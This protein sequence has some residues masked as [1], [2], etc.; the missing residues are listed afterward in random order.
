MTRLIPVYNWLLTT[1]VVRGDQCL[2]SRCCAD[3]WWLVALDN[4]L[5]LGIMIVSWSNRFWESIFLVRGIFK[6]LYWLTGNRSP[7]L[8]DLLLLIS[9]SRLF[10][11]RLAINISFCIPV[12]I[13]RSIYPHIETL[14]LKNTIAL[15]HLLYRWIYTRFLVVLNVD[16]VRVCYVSGRWEWVSTGRC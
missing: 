2:L 4:R 9:R 16:L 5:R 12:E 1:H 3:N 7:K 8:V 11:E 15:L 6:V 10:V 14:L 13:S